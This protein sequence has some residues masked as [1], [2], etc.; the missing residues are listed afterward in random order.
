MMIAAFKI[1]IQQQEGMNMSPIY[2]LTGAIL[3]LLTVCFEVDS[4]RLQQ[5]SL[6]LAHCAPAAACTG[7]YSPSWHGVF[8]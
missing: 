8:R 5:Q 7:G 4:A 1:P 6:A 2:L 3:L